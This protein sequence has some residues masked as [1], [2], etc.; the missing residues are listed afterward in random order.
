MQSR[1]DDWAQ[2][3]GNLHQQSTISMDGTGSFAPFWGQLA[4]FP[5]ETMGFGDIYPAPAFELAL[6]AIVPAPRGGA[7]GNEEDGSGV[8]LGSSSMVQ[9][10]QEPGDDSPSGLVIIANCDTTITNLSTSDPTLYSEITGAITA[11]IDFYEAAI[12]NPITITIG[13][14][15]G[16]LNNGRDVIGSNDLGES[17]A[18]G[19]PHSYDY[20]RDA[21][22]AHDTAA[23][24]SPLPASDPLSG[25][26][27]DPN[28]FI[29]DSELLALGGNPGATVDGY[30][31]LSSTAPFTYNPSDRAV[32]GEYDAIGVL[33]HEISEAMGRNADYPDVQAWY[34][35]L[36]L[37]RYSSPGALANDGTL[38]YF[39]ING[40]TTDLD[41][42]NDYQANSGDA[43]DWNTGTTIVGGTTFLPVPNDSY[44][45]FS[46]P[47][48]ATTVS[49]TD[50]TVMEMLGYSL[51]PTC[52]AAGTRIL[53]ARGEVRV[54]GLAVGDV[55]RARFAGLAPIKWI[56]HRR[57][58]CRR[59]P[60]PQQVWPVR[61]VAGAFAP[62]LPC[63]DLF[64]SPDHAVAVDGA[65]IPIRLLVNGASIRQEAGVPEVHYFHIELDRH[66]LLLADGLAA[67]S[68]L[69]TGNRGMFANAG[70]PIVLYPTLEEPTA[71]QRREAGSCLK[72]L[73]DPL[74]VEPVWQAL[75]ARAKS[76]GLALPVIATT[77]DP[78][79][80][81]VAGVRRFAP[82][83]QDGG[84]FTFVLPALP[85]GARLRSRCSV[86]SAVRPWLEDR[87]RLGVMVR[88][89]ALHCGTNVV[90]VAPDDPRLCDGWW[91]AEGDEATRW[92][93][94]DGDAALPPTDDF[95]ILEV[96]IGETPPYPLVEPACAG[97][98]AGLHPAALEVVA[99]NAAS[100]K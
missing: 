95:A 79:L 12:T 73:G 87:R 76:L 6:G 62:N 13:F 36:D 8:T 17:L 61:I 32:S 39:S 90:D 49:P 18:E 97:E 48:V 85:G 35:P 67:E 19:L 38:A 81:I 50:L 43:G 29:A 72:L 45:A 80:C 78:A 44:D 7:A 23:G 75:A 30:V 69:D 99:A 60:D 3:N 58:D 65:L 2:G 83:Q 16:E 24:A 57:I 56:G 25:S 26:S 71:Q 63:R 31:G 42:F 5:G 68:Y 1:S 98:L 52:Y 28:W 9:S 10:T 22:D 92:R 66:D 27:T 14:G 74:D 41:A 82:V 89:I 11:A 88:H 54:E 53:T 100:T 70:V 86:P 33:E 93:W 51:A 55:V 94:T 64:L 37:F 77:H 59:H 84:G 96:L 34:S 4:G 21:L 40:G 20:F 91:A 15:Y 46:G 47:G